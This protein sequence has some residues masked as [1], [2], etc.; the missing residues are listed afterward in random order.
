MIIR[1]AEISDLLAMQ[2]TNL[3]CLPENYQFKYYLY[4]AMSWPQLS[5]VAV[6][7]KGR[8]VA[9]ILSK[10]DDESDRPDNLIGHITSLAVLRSH[11]RL[12]IAKRLVI[13]TIMAMTNNYDAQFASLHVRVSN[14][15]AIKL[16][17][18]ILNFRIVSTETKYYADGED[19]FAMKR[20]LSDFKRK[21]LPLNVDEEVDCTEKD[22]CESGVDVFA[23]SK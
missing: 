3:M 4:H 17:Q 20:E 13:Q 7:G 11:R 23:E 15:A 12:G 9:Y 19:A 18:D 10:M 5:F 21:D 2:T 6:D 14:R 16:Y 22:S 1:Q 8:C